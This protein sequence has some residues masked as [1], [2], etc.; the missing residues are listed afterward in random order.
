LWVLKMM[1]PIALVLVFVF[2]YLMGEFRSLFAGLIGYRI[3][4]A[5]GIRYVTPPSFQ[6]IMTKTQ[7]FKIWFTRQLV[8]I[9]NVFVWIPR[10]KSTRRD[11]KI[12]FNRLLNTLS[13][14]IS[15]LYIFMMTTAAEIFVCTSQKNKS[16]TLNESSDI[17]W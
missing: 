2:I 10:H 3:V 8:W 15:F 7:E 12:F 1:I 6:P 9:Y 13:A 5:L 11:L 4:K 16:Y 14:Y 17:L